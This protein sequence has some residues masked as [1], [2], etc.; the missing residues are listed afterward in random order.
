MSLN[1]RSLVESEM[2]GTTGTCRT[3]AF[4]ESRPEDELSGWATVLADKGLYPHS[5]ISRAMRKASPDMLKPPS[6]DS[7]AAHRQNGHR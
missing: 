1:V 6:A 7:V 4:L 3:C 2:T 5:A